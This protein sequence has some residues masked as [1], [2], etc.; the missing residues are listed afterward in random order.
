[1]FFARDIVKTAHPLLCPLIGYPIV[2]K[3]HRQA[4]PLFL[5]GGREVVPDAK[6]DGTLACITPKRS[7][8]LSH[9]VRIA[10]RSSASSHPRVGVTDEGYASWRA[11]RYA[12]WFVGLG[13]C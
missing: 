10:V 7:W 2:F 8:S 6:H 1:M 13:R 3:I 12:G 9:A 4:A 5:D 11:P